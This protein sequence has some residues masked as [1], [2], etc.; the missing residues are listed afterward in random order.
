MLH[1]GGGLR[2]RVPHLSHSR[3]M[4][5]Q[6]PSAM[7]RIAHPTHL[8][9]ESADE[10]PLRIEPAVLDEVRLHDQPAWTGSITDHSAR[11]RPRLARAWTSQDLEAAS[12]VEGDGAQLSIVEVAQVRRRGQGGH[13]DGVQARQRPQARSTMRLTD[14]LRARAARSAG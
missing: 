3:G 8:V 9:R 11:Q 4:P 12:L 5:T 13:G 1:L 2:V 7:C 6:H 14:M 10:Q